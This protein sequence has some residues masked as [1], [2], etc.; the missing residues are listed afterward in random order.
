MPEDRKMATRPQLLLDVDAA[1]RAGDAPRAMSLARRALAMGF[2]DPI[3]LGLS[4]RSHEESG[5][6]PQACAELEKALAMTPRDPRLLNAH[7]RCLNGLGHFRRAIAAGETALTIDPGSAETHYNLAFAHEQLGQLDAARQAYERAITL[8]PA[9]ADATA[10]LAGLAARRGDWGEARALAGQALVESPGHVAAEFAHVMAD[11][12]EH[13]FGEAESRARRIADNPHIVPPARAHARAFLA[14]AL[15]GQGR[16]ADAFQAYAQA[17]AA[18]KLLS[19]SQF[20]QPGVETARALA[21]RL[22]A[23]FAA[24]DAQAW[25]TPDMGP[26]ATNSPVFILGFPRSGTTLLAEILA[27]H[28]ATMLL[29]EK[30][31]L[32]DA[33]AEFSARPGGLARLAAAGPDEIAHW[34]GLYWRRVEE[35]GI[36]AQGKTLIDKAPINTLHLPVIARLF[37][38]ARIV[39]ALRDPRDVVFSCFRRMF[40]LNM[41][42]YE[43]LSLPGAAAFY[44]ATMALAQIYRARLPLSVLEL[45]NEDLIADFDTQARR[46]CAFAGLAWNDTMTDFARRK[47]RRAIANP[48]AVQIARG[49]SGESQAQWR[50]YAAAMEPVLPLLAPWVRRFGYAP[51]D[52]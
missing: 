14:D 4:A 44:D 1:L 39:F 41:F 20:E 34:R 47:D 16:M 50:R 15:D 51:D 49:L 31:V 45:R 2:S 13:R 21:A 24:T 10:R 25:Q 32:R 27:S 33:I 3:L 12:A 11:L 28:P 42:L 46:L 43:L 26:P 5:N 9:M 29:D 35:T 30:P 36:H 7:A 8:A 6:L 48:G 23:E 17:N 18:L 52:P 37:P 22:A 38:Q 19:R 40:A